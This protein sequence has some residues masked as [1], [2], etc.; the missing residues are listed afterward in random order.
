MKVPLVQLAALIITL[1][2]LTGCMLPTPPGA[3]APTAEPA[4]ASSAPRTTQIVADAVVVPQR[5]VDVAFDGGGTVAAVLVKEGDA[6]ATGAPLA[7]LATRDLELQVAQNQANLAQAQAAYNKIA[8]G[9]TPEEIAAQ[10]AQVRNAEA[11]L[12]QT[13][14]GNVTAADVAGAQAQL[15]Q[16]EAAQALLRNPAAGDHSAAEER[17]RQAE[18]ALQATRDSTSQAKT[19]SE[20]AMERAVD[21]LTQ[22][23]ASYSKAKSDWNYVQE[24]GNDP[25]SPKT[26]DGKGNRVNNKLGESQWAQ[27]ATALVQAQAQLSSAEKAVTDAQVAFEHARQNE[28]S[29]IQ[30]AESQLT[31]A[32]AQLVALQNPDKNWLAQQQAV[33]DQASANLGR[34]QKGGSQ[35]EIAAAQAVVAQ[36]QASLAGLTVPP[37]SVDLAEAQARIEAAQVALEQAE[38]TVEKATLRAPFAGVIAERNLEVGQRIESSAGANTAPFVLAEIGQWNIETSN[39]SERDVV[40]LQVG[41]AAQMTFDALPDLAL[42]G[43][44][45]AI[46]PRGVDQYGDKTYTVTATPDTR[47][48][49]LR[50]NMSASV[51]IEPTSP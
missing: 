13:R 35:A 41:S 19:S 37:R 3:P 48:Q 20:L 45:T 9:A 25:A 12:T 36:Q 18:V 4:P 7:R 14:Q 22:A 46:K 31:D 50:W 17:A 26:T 51:A 39:L 30:T 5:Y 49:R 10:Q 44:V 42:P 24:T 34:V 1:S 28:V 2:V 47:D 16:A 11:N 8:A 21:G 6:V 29:S 38:R 15:R 23:Q 40:C 32:Q 27:D 33:V 43:K